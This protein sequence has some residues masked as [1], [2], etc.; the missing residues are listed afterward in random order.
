VDVI[1]IDNLTSCPYHAT[2]VEQVLP[3]SRSEKNSLNFIL[4]RIV[5]ISK[6]YHLTTYETRRMLPKEAEIKFWLHSD[7][8]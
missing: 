6:M 3:Q 1:N 7:K 2:T 4:I 8:Y 5:P